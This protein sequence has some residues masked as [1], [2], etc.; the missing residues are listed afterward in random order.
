[1]AEPAATAAGT[2]KQTNRD[3]RGVP[4]GKCAIIL[5][6]AGGT[7]TFGPGQAAAGTSSAR[8]WGLV[9]AT[10]AAT[11]AGAGGPKSHLSGRPPRA[12]ISAVRRG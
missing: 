9:P 4:P 12:R 7:W 3:E 6:A 8:R 11:S 10:M 5:G 2:D 1:M